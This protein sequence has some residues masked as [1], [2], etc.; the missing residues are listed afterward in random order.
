LKQPQALQGYRQQTL[1]QPWPVVDPQQLFK[2]G[3]NKGKPFI[4]ILRQD[5]SYCR[6]MLDH[7][8]TIKQPD[9]QMFVKYLKTHYQSDSENVKE[10]YVLDETPPYVAEENTT[11]VPFVKKEETPIEEKV[12]QMESTL[13]QVLQFLQSQTQAPI[14]PSSSSA[15]KREIPP[16]E[17]E[18]EP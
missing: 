6:W 14:R 2:N 17:D 9:L 18:M 12:E 15:S 4:H 7:A 8:D 1:S 16:K 3:K 13:A 11:S 10:V 5:P